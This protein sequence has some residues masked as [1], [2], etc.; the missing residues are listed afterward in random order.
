MALLGFVAGV[1]VL[2][3]LRMRYTINREAKRRRPKTAVASPPIDLYALKRVV[4][5]ISSLLYPLVSFL[6]PHA[7]PEVVS[8]S[9]RLMIFIQGNNLNLSGACESG[10]FMMTDILSPAL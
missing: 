3:A 10:S 2:I 1:R 7:Q 6:P 5:K 9:H 4:S 8:L